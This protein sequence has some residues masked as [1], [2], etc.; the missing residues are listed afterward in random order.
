MKLAVMQPYFLPYLGYFQ[1]LQAADTFVFFDDVNYIKKGWINKNQVL[2]NN[3]AYK[4]T[5]P[6]LKA[7]QNKLINE[8]YIS[9]YKVWREDFMKLIELNYKKAPYFSSTCAWLK[10]LLYKK[11]FELISDLASESIIAASKLLDIHVELC[12]SSQLDYRKST[13][14]NGQEKI[15]SICR[16]LGGTEYINPYNGAE[17]YNND[18]FVKSGVIL[19]FL[20]MNEIRYEQLKK[21]EFIPYLSILDVLMFNEIDAIKQ[22]LNNYSLIHA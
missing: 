2:A 19:H 15:L 4:F 22:F 5:V 11:D 20:K 8:V 1:L 3:Q 18:D 10:E 9:D 17:L 6:L 16:L 7:S 12:Y 14:S 13:T 21:G